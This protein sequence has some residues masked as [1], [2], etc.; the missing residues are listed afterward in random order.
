[1]TEFNC[2]VNIVAYSVVMT[3]T[4]VVGVVNMDVAESLTGTTVVVNSNDQ[5]AQV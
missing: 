5:C 3:M 1:M 2:S 4:F